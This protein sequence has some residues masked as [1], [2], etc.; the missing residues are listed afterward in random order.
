MPFHRG[1]KGDYNEIFFLQVFHR[2]IVYKP[3]N[4]NLMDFFFLSS[5]QAV[6]EEEETT[7]YRNQKI[8]NKFRASVPLMAYRGGFWPIRG[9]KREYAKRKL[10]D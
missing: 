8:L 7:Y 5:Y 2:S 4:I 1:V 3:S 9:F 6:E 10:N